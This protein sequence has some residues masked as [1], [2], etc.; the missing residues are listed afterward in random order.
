MKG[1][2]VESKKH[3]IGRYFGNLGFEDMFLVEPELGLMVVADGVTRDPMRELPDKKNLFGM[4]KFVRNYPKPSPAGE[5]VSIVC[6]DLPYGYQWGGSL[7]N[8]FNY[9]NRKIAEWNL[10]NIP[11][12]DYVMNDLAGCVASAVIVDRDKGILKWGYVCDCGVAVLNGKGDLKFRTPDEGPNKN[13]A[14]RKAILDDMGLE[15]RMPECRRLT[16]TRFRNNPDDPYSFGVLTGEKS[17]M[18]YIRTG[19]ERLDWG[20]SVFVYT[21]GVGEVIFGRDG[22]IDGGFVDALIVGS[23]NRMEKF[24]KG[25]VESEGTL[26]SYTGQF[27]R[28]GPSVREQEKMELVA[29]DNVL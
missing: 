27:P 11:E 26:A 6:N 12:P 24:C 13:G 20:D 25:K 8:G 18:E 22:D 3:R 15:W 4:L 5:A 19:E 9:A 10:K 16:R 14:E 23:Y 2:I 28:N 21:D 7:L 29:K 1:F 17:A